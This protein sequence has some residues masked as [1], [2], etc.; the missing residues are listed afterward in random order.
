[1]D[2]LDTYKIIEDSRETREKF[3][4]VRDEIRATIAE[5]R[6]RRRHSQHE[7]SI[8]PDGVM[9]AVPPPDATVQAERA[10]DT[11]LPE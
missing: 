3:A 7:I 2:Y 1:M 10:T 8:S 4:R 9:T 5:I 6:E 11:Y